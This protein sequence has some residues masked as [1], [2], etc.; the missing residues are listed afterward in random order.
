MRTSPYF[1]M[2]LAGRS[3]RLLRSTEG[4]LRAHR[5]PQTTAMSIIQ[6]LFSVTVF[7]FG[8]ARACLPARP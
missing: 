3:V 7:C 6:T 5:K 8:Q 4:R 1:V 2:P